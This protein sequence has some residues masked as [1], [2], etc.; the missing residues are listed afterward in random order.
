[1]ESAATKLVHAAAVK[2]LHAYN[3][4]RSSSTAAITLSDLLARYLA[5]LSESCAKYARHAGRTN[6]SV[7]DAVAVL[8]ELGIGMDELADFCAS[9]AKELN[10]YAS[11]SVRRIEDL[12]EFRAHLS[13]GLKQ[14]NDDAIPL[15]FQIYHGED[16][17][18]DEDVDMEPPPM[19]VDTRK[20]PPLS[21]P[22]PPLPL[23]PVSN[24]SSPSRKRPR[25]AS[26]KPPPHIPAFLPPFPTI[27]P[28]PSRPPS[29]H[30]TETQ[31]AE[32]M[33]PPPDKP[34][35]VSQAMTAPTASDYL[36]Q[37]PYSQSS[38]SSIPEWHLPTPPKS[39]KPPPRK[40]ALPTLQSEPALFKA[41]H[42]ILTHPPPSTPPP[43]N[44][45]RHKVAMAFLSQTQN[46]PRWDA[47]DTVFSTIAPC[48]P[49]VATIGPTYPVA[50][51]DPINGKLD[52]KDKEF[53]FPPTIPR[54]VSTTERLTPLLGQQSHRIPELARHVLPP[55]VMSRTTRL[56]HPPVLN[57]GSK[58][59]LYGRGI[60]APWN[61]H[62]IPPADSTNNLPPTPVATSTKD[63]VRENGETPTKSHIPDAQL[64]ATWDF[65]TKDYKLP[66]PSSHRQH[67][68]RVASLTS[69]QNSVNLGTASRPKAG[70]PKHG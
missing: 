15:E 58:P 55:V 4:S 2:T 36:A 21:H 69:G 34:A 41:Y 44:L 42:H 67:R 70:P 23:S 61:S 64:F 56:V 49:R 13:T 5:L 47:A 7:Y 38:L 26:W 9:E 1:M 6:L 60:P 48:P 8:D 33:P 11:N 22:S 28:P 40:N 50:I 39:F 31:P 59:V 12:N 62:A 63:K 19:P 29:P 24:P 68:T 35:V 20:T 30:E 18:D 25:T 65:E 54:P 32:L 37:V 43:T 17:D 52:S 53:R 16:D 14:D 3:F 46:M 51:N 27:E 57:R 66:L 45:S 10:R